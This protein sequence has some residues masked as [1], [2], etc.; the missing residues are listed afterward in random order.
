MFG[1]TFNGKHSFNDLGLIMFSQNRPIL[2]EAKI[3]TEEISGKDGEYDFSTVNPD[4]RIKYKNRSME[5]K[6]TIKER[7]LIT[8]RQKAHSVAEWLACGEQN[9][10]FDDDP[11]VY[12]IAKVTNKV[13]LEHQIII[14][15]EFTVYFSCKP[16]CYSSTLTTSTHAVAANGS[17]TVANSGTYVKPV[18]RISGACDTI[19]FAVNGK[20][21]TY[22]APIA[23]GQPIEIDCEGGTAYKSGTSSVLN[24]VSGDFIELIKGNNVVVIAGTNLNCEVSFVFRSKYL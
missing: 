1:L 16:Y 11:N 3:I 10:I 19:S 21:L 5:I 24:N 12:W 20:T 14:T 2:P 22:T 18:I 7:D 4:K 13:D 6:F 17:K 15:K 23:V 9:L 8:L